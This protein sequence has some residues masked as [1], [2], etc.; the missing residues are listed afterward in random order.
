MGKFCSNIDI[1]TVTGKMVWK[2]G[3]DLYEVFEN[4]WYNNEWYFLLV[5]IS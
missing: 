3:K 2:I 5:S 4:F 1:L